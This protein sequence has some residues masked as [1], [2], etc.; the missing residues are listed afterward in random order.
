MPPNAEAGIPDDDSMDMLM[1]AV[2]MNARGAADFLSEW[3]RAKELGRRSSW[4]CGAVAERIGI[5]DPRYY[6]KEPILTK[7]R[8]EIR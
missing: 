4:T 6:V 2:E 5:K 7:G 1:L 3:A 8:E